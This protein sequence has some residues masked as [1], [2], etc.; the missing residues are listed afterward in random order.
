MMRSGLD[1][2]SVAQ[3]L[4]FWIAYGIFA[5]ILLWLAGL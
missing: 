5:G 3:L 4:A 1:W 2:I